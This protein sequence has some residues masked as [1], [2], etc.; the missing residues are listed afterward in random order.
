MH[1]LGAGPAPRGGKLNGEGMPPIKFP[2]VNWVR[3]RLLA[4]I[5]FFE[6]LSDGM[7]TRPSFKGLAGDEDA[8]SVHLELTG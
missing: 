2:T 4:E 6:I 1:G 5:E 7:I 8:R 3:P